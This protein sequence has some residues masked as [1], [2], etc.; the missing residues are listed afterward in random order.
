MVEDHLSHCHECQL[1]VTDLHSF[2]NEIA[3]S[4]DREYRP[5][6]NVA[7]KEER[8]SVFGFLSAPFRV[9]PAPAF[10]V[11][12]KNGSPSDKNWQ[13]TN[14]SEWA[15]AA[16]LRALTN[17]FIGKGVAVSNQRQAWVC[18][19]GRPKPPVQ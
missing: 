19:Q 1:E 2:R 13:K 5:A 7:V 8:R 18:G 14:G 3:P 17:L 16:N 11:E 6:T 15:T 9:A 10:G 4:L 12:P